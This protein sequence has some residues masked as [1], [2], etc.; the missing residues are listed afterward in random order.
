MII[1]PIDVA[2]IVAA[3]RLSARLIDACDQFD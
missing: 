1:T 2:V 3:P